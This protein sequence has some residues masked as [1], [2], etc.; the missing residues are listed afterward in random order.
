M[1][2]IGSLD[3]AQISDT[4]GEVSARGRQ[5]SRFTNLAAQLITKAVLDRELR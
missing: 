1:P 2:V 5:E 3:I 4:G